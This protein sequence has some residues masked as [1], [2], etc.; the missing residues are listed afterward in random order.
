IRDAKRDW[1]EK[2]LSNPSISDLWEAAGWRHGRKQ[3]GIPHLTKPNGETTSSEQEKAD[4]LEETFIKQT[5]EP[6]A[7]KQPDDPAP[8]PQRHYTPINEEEVKDAVKPTSNRSA[9]GESGIGWKLL[10]WAVEAN[11]HIF[12]NIYNA[13]LVHRVHPWKHAIIIP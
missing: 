1:A 4:L 12:P 5:S 13:C 11:P 2:F 3:A 7:D 10:K 6:C 8:R 9:P